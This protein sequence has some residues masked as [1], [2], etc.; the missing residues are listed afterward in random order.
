MKCD[1][2]VIGAGI[3]GVSSAYHLKKR[4]PKKRVVMID[5]FSSAGSGNSS[6]SQAAFRNIFTSKE[7]YLL[8]DSTINA[9]IHYQNCMGYDIKLR[10]IGY[11][12]LFSK[13][14]YTNLKSIFRT[15][16]GRGADIKTF[17]RKELEQIIPHLRTNFSGDKDAEL[18]DLEPV[19]IGVQGIKCGCIDASALIQCIERE[20]LKLGG[21]TQYNVEAKRLILKPPLLSL[22]E[23]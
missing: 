23:V 2:L 18:M 3:I 6:K 4:N 20:F 10:Q 9:F 7:N 13:N 19:D 14:Q 15:I 22:V 8:A 17:S 1:I 16:K 5:K 12:W 21:E 11:L